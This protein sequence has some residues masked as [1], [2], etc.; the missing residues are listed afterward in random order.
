[1]NE[2]AYF[3]SRVDKKCPFSC[4]LNLKNQNTYL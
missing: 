2:K 1:M 3:F 4:L